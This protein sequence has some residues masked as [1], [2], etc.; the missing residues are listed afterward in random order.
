M[1]TTERELGR[2]MVGGGQADLNRLNIL[3]TS[4]D[5]HTTEI[6]SA[7]DLPKNA[8]CLELASG[9]GSVTEILATMFP[10]GSVH[11]VDIDL[12]PL[13]ANLPSNVTTSQED[14]TSEGFDPGSERYDLIHARYILSHL[15]SRDNL[16]RRAAQ[17]LKPG[18]WLVSTE[19]FHLD[20]DSSAYPEVAR[21]MRAYENVAQKG[22]AD[23]RWSRRA[24]SIMASAGLTN[25]SSIARP[26][27]LGGG[28]DRDR[29]APLLSPVTD[30]LIADGPVTADEL[31][32]LHTNLANPDYIDIPQVII[33][34]IGQKRR[35]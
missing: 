2:L 6:I 17:W 19:P 28:A 25:I 23:L 15:P 5:Q 10:S 26:G 9:G 16:V 7:L 14:I 30:A 13:P 1:S 32:T 18:G 12:A 8:A 24:P 4:T 31:A 35:S 21:A 27:L 33:T 34:T 29:W 3:G 20:P 11:A 22:A